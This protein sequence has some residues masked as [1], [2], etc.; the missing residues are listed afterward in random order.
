MAEQIYDK[1][2]LRTRVLAHLKAQGMHVSTWQMAMAMGTQLYAVDCVLEDAYL[3][4][5]VAFSPG[6]G[7]LL[8]GEA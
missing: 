2:L 6:F 3:A 1:T 4:G 8:R 7:W 5:E